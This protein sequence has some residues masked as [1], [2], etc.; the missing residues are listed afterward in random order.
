MGAPRPI[1]LLCSVAALGGA[2]S[3]PEPAPERTEPW[4]APALQQPHRARVVPYAIADPSEILVSLSTREATLVGVMR[5]A[6]GRLQ[7][8]LH[9]LSRTRGTIRVDITSLRMP[10]SESV[11]E[12]RRQTAVAQNWLD[13]GSNQPEPERDRKRWA[14][15]VISEIEEVSAN[16][17]HEGKRVKHSQL[18][19]SDSGLRQAPEG[20]DGALGAAPSGEVREVRMVARGEL[21]LH[22]YR[23]EHTTRLRVRFHYRAAAG[24]QET[25]SKLTIETRS[26]LAVSLAAHDIKPRDASGVF[27]ARDMK[28]LGVQVARDAR[29]SLR[30]TA[31]PQG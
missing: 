12:S 13:V 19:P 4:P 22:G 5:V 20:T 24:A 28:L 30:L 25:P 3:K 6:S 17:A 21:S 18:R 27:I 10:G 29:A 9:E 1:L 31:L 16:A 14:E 26:P 11:A 15:F 23:V 8:D 2:C 7:I